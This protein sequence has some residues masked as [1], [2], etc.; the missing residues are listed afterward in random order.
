MSAAFP[1]GDDHVFQQLEGSRKRGCLKNLLR[2]YYSKGK[3]VRQ[4]DKGLKNPDLPGGRGCFFFSE[5]VPPSHVTLLEE[6]SRGGGLAVQGEG[7]FDT[8]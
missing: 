6:R 8:Q 4:T 1:V 2:C 3:T 7:D 5:V